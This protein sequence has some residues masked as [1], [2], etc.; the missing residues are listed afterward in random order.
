MALSVLLTEL[1]FIFYPLTVRQKGLS[2]I[3]ERAE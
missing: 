1:L 3:Q 2:L